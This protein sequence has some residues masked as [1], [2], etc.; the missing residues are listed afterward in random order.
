MSY[1]NIQQVILTAFFYPDGPEAE[2][3]VRKV[4]DDEL[5][6]VPGLDGVESVSER[7]ALLM[8]QADAQRSAF[9]DLYGSPYGVS[10][11]SNE[12]I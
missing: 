6:P 2:L 10:V 5:P 1:Q 7:A 9:I 4:V 12:Q 11:P 8:A 3:L